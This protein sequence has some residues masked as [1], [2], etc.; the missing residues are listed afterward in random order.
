M[1]DQ[2][3]SRPSTQP[4][5]ASRPSRSI[6]QVPTKSSAMVAVGSSSTATP[7][8]VAANA[9]PFPSAQAPPSEGTEH[10]VINDDEDNV[11]VGC[12]RKMKSDVWLEFEQVTIGSKMK[13]ECTWCKKLLVR[14]RRAGTNHLCGHLRCYQSRQVRKGLKQTSLKL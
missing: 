3:A 5:G 8:S 12:K 11:Q 7:T 14:D 1:S 13:V 9:M 2:G 10:V 4:Q 6:H